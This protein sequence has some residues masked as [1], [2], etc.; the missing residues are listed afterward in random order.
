MVDKISS[1]DINCNLR[2]KRGRKRTGKVE[3]GGGGGREEGGGGREEGG[4]GGEE[5]G[6]GGRGREEGREECETET[7]VY[8]V[9]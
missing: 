8:I 3:E 9:Y 6:G 5:G 1:S 7:L 2:D 4:G